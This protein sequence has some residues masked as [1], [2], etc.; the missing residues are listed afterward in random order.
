MRAS[1]LLYS[2]AGTADDDKARFR[3]VDVEQLKGF[4]QL[5]MIFLGRETANRNHTERMLFHKFIQTAGIAAGNNGFWLIAN[6]L[7]CIA[8]NLL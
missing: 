2:W 8:T 3:V 4:D 7:F 6:R 5:G 1:V